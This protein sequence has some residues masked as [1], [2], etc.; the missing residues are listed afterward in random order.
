M[1]NPSEIFRCKLYIIKYIAY[2][3]NMKAQIYLSFRHFSGAEED[4]LH[5]VALTAIKVSNDPLT[6]FSIL[7]KGWWTL[8]MAKSYIPIVH[9]VHD[10]M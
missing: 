8:A 10:T 1:Y 3:S 4:R 2:A 6:Y 9:L 5:E 7:F